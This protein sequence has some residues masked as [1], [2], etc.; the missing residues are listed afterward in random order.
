[1]AR[2]TAWKMSTYGVF[3][4]PYFPVFGLNTEIYCINIGIQSKYG[5][6]QTRINFVFGHFSRSENWPN[7]YNNIKE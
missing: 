3:F 7:A 2:D 6:L 5:K 1:M 4:Y